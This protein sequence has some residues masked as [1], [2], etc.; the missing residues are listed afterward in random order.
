MDCRFSTLQDILSLE[1]F[2]TVLLFALGLDVCHIADLLETSERSVCNSLGQ[3]F[4]QLG[5]GSVHELTQR[6]LYEWE[7]DLYDERLERELAKLQSAARRMLERIASPGESGMF[8]E[9]RA[10]PSPKWVN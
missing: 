8:V 3:C 4:V 9:N 7:N 6:L 10:L 5:C 2:R 1:E